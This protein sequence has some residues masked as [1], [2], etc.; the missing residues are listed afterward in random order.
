[1]FVEAESLFFKKKSYANLYL[2]PCRLL[3]L[4]TLIDL[5]LCVEQSKM[6]EARDESRRKAELIEKQKLEARSMVSGCI[7]FNE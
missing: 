7:Y 4:Y 1:M 5:S 3:H 6:N 2:N